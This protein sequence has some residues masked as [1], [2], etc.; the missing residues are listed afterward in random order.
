MSG[1]DFR[2]LSK[3]CLDVGDCLAP[4]DCTCYLLMTPELDAELRARAAAVSDTDQG[5]QP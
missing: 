2:F 5:E 4:T 1:G 3:N